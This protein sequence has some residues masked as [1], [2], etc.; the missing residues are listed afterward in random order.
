MSFINKIFFF[1]IIVSA[2]AAESTK[3]KKLLIK[4]HVNAYYQPEQIHIS[5][6]G[7]F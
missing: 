1:I 2:S 5:Y 4:N 7:L 6:G 3:L